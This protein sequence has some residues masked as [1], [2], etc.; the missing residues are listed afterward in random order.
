MR[1]HLGRPGVVDQ[2]VESS[3]VIEDFGDETRAVFVLGDVGL[4]VP[5]VRRHGGQSF[6]GF[7]AARGVEDDAVAARRETQCSRFADAARRTGH[8]DDAVAHGYRRRRRHEPA[9]C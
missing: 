7:D 9:Q 2:H 1:N 4:H 6:T 8:E 5:R 3:V